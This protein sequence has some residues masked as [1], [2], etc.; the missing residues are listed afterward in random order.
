MTNSKTI[1]IIEDSNE[2][3]EFTVLA[4]RKSGLHNHIMRC[5]SGDDALDYLFRQG[6]Y[7]DPETSP[8]PNLILLD[9]NLPGVDGRDVLDTIKKDSTLTVIPV[10]VLTTSNDKVDVEECYAHGANSYVQ[11]PVDFM[12]LMQAI[13]RL[14]EYWFEVVILP[15][16]GY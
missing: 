15:K 1:L 2:D 12:G 14:K 10:I 16:N 8:V 11:K 7:S 3:F 4:L 13:Q 5:V 9:L 6:K